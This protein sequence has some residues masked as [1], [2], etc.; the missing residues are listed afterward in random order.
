MDKSGFGEEEM[1]V[2]SMNLTDKQKVRLY[3]EQADGSV[4][5][6]LGHPV[7]IAKRKYQFT[8]QAYERY[9]Y[10]NDPQSGKVDEVPQR[11][12]SVRIHNG[13]KSATTYQ[14]YTLDSKG[15]NKSN[16]NKG[17]LNMYQDRNH[18]NQKKSSKYSRLEGNRRN[19]RKNRHI[20]L[21]NKILL[22]RRSRKKNS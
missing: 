20:V 1:E 14:D 3:Q 8:A 11:G 15:Q 10:N 2:S 4:S 6:L 19:S 21:K 17:R 9:Y 12:G 16:R 7:F 22:N 13:L 5:Y 18:E